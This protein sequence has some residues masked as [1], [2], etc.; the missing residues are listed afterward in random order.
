MISN[1]SVNIGTDNTKFESTM[2][3]VELNFLSDYNKFLSKFLTF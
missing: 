2:L 3:L 1:A